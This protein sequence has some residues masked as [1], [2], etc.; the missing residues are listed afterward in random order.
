[1]V[2][3]VVFTILS[4]LLLGILGCQSFPV[5]QTETGEQLSP[6][7]GIPFPIGI[8]VYSS[9]ISDDVAAQCE[10]NLTDNMVCR[11][12]GIAA[13]DFLSTLEH[14]QLFKELSPSVTR[15]DY[16]LLIAN[17][18]IS[19]SDNLDSTPSEGQQSFTEFAVEWRGVGIHS[20]TIIYNHQGSVRM[21]DVEQIVLQWWQYAEQHGIFTTP[22]LYA[23]L[24]AS[25]Y[26]ANL[27][28]PE[29]LDNFSLSQR[30]LHPD[31]FKGVL[32]RYLHPEFEEAIMDMSIYPVLAPI[33]PTNKSQ[34]LRQELIKAVEQ[35]QKVASA[36][37][38]TLTIV[39][40]N[41]TFS[42]EYPFN[43]GFMTEITA[44]SETGE[45]IF[46]TVYVF[47]MQDKIVKFNT[48]FPARIGDDLVKKALPQ[49]VVPSESA[50]MKEIR[51]AL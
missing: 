30:Y 16:E 14:I 47:Q 29:K 37:A 2:K 36:K 12:D 3:S 5:G 46:A 27:T 8:N 6:P 24:N 34:M 50:L 35:A 39:Q 25:D 22:Y 31:P 51:Q 4:L 11:N 48:T 15:H 1:M 33:T 7:V 28:I 42:V 43:E 38:M 45:V 10:A 41:K 13:S 23:A 19:P 26:T 49:I 9:Y 32:A 40:E 20:H 44:E 17:Q 18:L 21:E